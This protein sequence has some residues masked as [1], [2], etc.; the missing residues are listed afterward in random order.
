MT[1]NEPN[2]CYALAKLLFTEFC[3]Q[4][5]FCVISFQTIDQSISTKADFATS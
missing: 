5:L 2:Q 4:F 3:L 1:A